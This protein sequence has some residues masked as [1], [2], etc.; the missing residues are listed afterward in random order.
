MSIRK[1]TVFF[2]A[3]LG[4]LVASPVF[5]QVSPL[6]PS[7]IDDL[8][9][10]QL[11]RQIKTACIEL[12][13]QFPVA[14][15]APECAEI[16]DACTQDMFDNVKAGLAEAFEQCQ[17]LGPVPSFQCELGI[18]SSGFIATEKERIADALEAACQPLPTP[19]AVDNNN[20]AGNA[21]ENGQIVADDVS[22]ATGGCSMTGLGGVSGN[23]LWMALGLLPLMGLRRN[24][25]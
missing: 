21:G 17:S 10:I 4:L 25:K 6:V 12:K 2:S 20:D 1:F 23:L 16:Q 11:R 22:A 19:P 7:Q 14:N 5:A 8:A 15:T 18:R 3:I 13:D 9:D 24:R